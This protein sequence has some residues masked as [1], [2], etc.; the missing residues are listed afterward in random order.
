MGMVRMSDQRRGVDHQESVA[1][2]A[3]VV[4][5]VMKVDW[6]SAHAVVRPEELASK[7]LG[8]GAYAPVAPALA[9]A[10][11]LKQ[12]EK[13]FSDYLYYNISITLLHHPTLKLHGQVGE[14]R[15][16]FRLRCEVEARRQRDA[17]LSKARAKLDQQIAR[18]EEKLRREQ[19]E[20]AMDQKELEARK[21]EE[22]L[23]LGESALNLLTR[24][25]SSYVV[26][27]ATRKR[28]LTK[29]AEAE[30]EESLDAIED[31][32]SQL[33][34]L[35]AQWGTQA[36][37]ISDRWANTVNEIEEF[38]LKPRR[39]DVRVEFCGVAWTPIWRVVLETGEQLEL[40]ARE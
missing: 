21:Q 29:Q 7:P 5:G 20:M 22:L 26:S 31:F 27:R 2:L 23:S 35:R 11:D 33:A 3:R 25:R 4:A 15:R 6:A 32:E 10:R 38:Q 19:R 13:E 18:V 39:T 34:E 24:R 17:E 30:V 9:R 40:P 37:E 1:R 8:E 36:A 28:T 14:S 12:L 16:D